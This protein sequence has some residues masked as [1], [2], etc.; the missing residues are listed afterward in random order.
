[1][2]RREFSAMALRKRLNVAQQAIMRAEETTNTVAQQRLWR[3]YNRIH[4]AFWEVIN[5]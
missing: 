3:R 5:A 2:T 1:M 4:E